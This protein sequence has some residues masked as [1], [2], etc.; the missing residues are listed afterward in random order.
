MLKYLIL[1]PLFGL[2]LTLGY[3]NREY[4]YNQDVEQKTLRIV[5][6]RSDFHLIPLFKQFTENTGVQIEAVF[7]EE[8]TLVSRVKERR[9]EVDIVISL[10]IT[11]L[12]LLKQSN[13]LRHLE[14]NQNLKFRYD[15]YYIPYSY[16]LRVLIADKNK[17]FEL[18]QISYELLENHS[19][20]I[21]PLN[22]TYNINLISQMISD[23]GESETARWLVGLGNNLAVEPQGNDR[24]Q[25]ELVSQ[26]ICDIGVIN[27]YYYGLMLN[28]DKRE[29]ASK[30]K[31][32]IP[33]PSYA[34]VS[35][36]G[37]LNL[38]KEAKEFLDFMLSPLVQSYIAYTQFE[39]PIIKNVELPEITKG[40]ENA[41]IKII[42]PEKILDS[43]PKAMELIQFM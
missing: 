6:D 17:E 25:A 28:S 18:N 32:L 34:L 21:R 27:S 3:L 20:C 11:N 31:L 24:K 2:L 1:V 37:I 42:E 43:K 7:L 36:I 41:E 39:L 35:G 33:N 14:I 40:L 30:L 26:G 5:S 15:D 16:R 12:E 9:D 22:H 38:S 8:G 23:I 29:V 4:V 19:V 10:D 13:L